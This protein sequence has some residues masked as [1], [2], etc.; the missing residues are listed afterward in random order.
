MGPR[1]AAPAAEPAG[2]DGA[3]IAVRPLPPAA[4]AAAPGPAAPQ[5]R[6]RGQ[7]GRARR[8]LAAGG[9]PSPPAAVRLRGSPPRRGDDGN[10]A[11]FGGVSAVS[12]G[13]PAGSRAGGC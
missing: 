12:L 10:M 5:N 3:S 2:T 7:G 4:V 11:G 8:P 6:R 9:P 13:I 1:P